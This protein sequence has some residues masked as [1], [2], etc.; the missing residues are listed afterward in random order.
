MLELQCT[1]T[2]VKNVFHGLIHRLDRDKK[3]ISDVSLRILQ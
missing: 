3:R 1:A 2:E